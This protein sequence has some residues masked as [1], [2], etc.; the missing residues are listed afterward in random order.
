MLNKT[1]IS[2]LYSISDIKSVIDKPYL[3]R[4]KLSLTKQEEHRK[5][6]RQ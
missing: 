5:R 6:L 1:T 4:Y 2:I 3:R